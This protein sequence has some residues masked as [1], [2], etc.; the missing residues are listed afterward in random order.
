MVVVPGSHGMCPFC[1][2]ALGLFGKGIAEQMQGC[3][4]VIIRI[5]GGQQE[6]ELAVHGERR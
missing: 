4:H 1:I 5:G 6:L 2:D 3:A